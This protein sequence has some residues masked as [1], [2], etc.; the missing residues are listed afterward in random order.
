[1]ILFAYK[2]AMGLDKKLLQLMDG[3][4]PNF[5]FMKNIP[6]ANRTCGFDHH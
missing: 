1:M 5:F 2:T 6:Q 4:F 3:S